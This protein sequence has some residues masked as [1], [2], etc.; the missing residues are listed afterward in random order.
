MI[1]QYEI[2]DKDG[3]SFVQKY[4]PSIFSSIMFYQVA[5]FGDSF[6]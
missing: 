3:P 4:G 5:I 1:E 6:L 2:R